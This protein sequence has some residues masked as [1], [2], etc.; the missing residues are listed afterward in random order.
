MRPQKGTSRDGSKTCQK[1][2]KRRVPSGEVLLAQKSEE[3]KVPPGRLLLGQ[4]S[5]PRWASSRPEVG[6]KEGYLRV[7]SFLRQRSQKEG[8][9][10]VGYFLGRRSHGRTR[11]GPSSTLWWFRWGSLL[12]C[13]SS[14]AFAASVLDLHIS[15]GVGGSLPHWDEVVHDM[16]HDL[17]L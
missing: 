12:A 16:S 3:K 8:C 10:N 4:K 14:Q 7:G 17:S 5:E 9:L 6:T 13:A 15:G 11:T 2:K 1:K